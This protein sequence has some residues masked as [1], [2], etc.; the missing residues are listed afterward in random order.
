MLTH[1]ALTGEPG[2]FAFEPITALPPMFQAFPLQIEPAALVVEGI[3]R[4]GPALDL[5]EWGRLAFARQSVRGG[6][7]PGRPDERGYQDC[8]WR[9]MILQ[10]ATEPRGD[11]K[12]T[13]IATLT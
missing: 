6:F 5:E 12:L 2:K 3:R 11:N 13:R 1:W 7:R 9:C 10:D 8:I 4:C